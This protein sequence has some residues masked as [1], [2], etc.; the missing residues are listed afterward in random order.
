VLAAIELEGDGRGYNFLLYLY[1][2]SVG[3]K[4]LAFCGLFNGLAILLTAKLALPR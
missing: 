4:G 3:A 2:G 1:S